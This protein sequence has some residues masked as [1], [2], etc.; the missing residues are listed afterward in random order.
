MYKCGLCLMES[1]GIDTKDVECTCTEYRDGKE[2]P[3]IVNDG[4]RP[5]GRWCNCDIDN[6]PV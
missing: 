3:L 6:L 2:R 4:E 1:V 5:H